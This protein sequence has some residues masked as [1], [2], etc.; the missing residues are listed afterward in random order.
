MALDNFLIQDPLGRPFDGARQL[1]RLEQGI[2]DA[3]ANRGR[4]ADRLAARPLPRARAEAFA[5]APRALIDNKASNRFTVIEVNAR[6]R[7]ALLSDLAHTL[8]SAKA[9]IKSAHVA[10]YGERAVDTFYVTDLTGQ[11][12]ETPTRLKALEKRLL[13]VAAGNKLELAA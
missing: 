8:F 6:D 2:A 4:L 12:I 11:K 7:P 13:A 5:I 1:A 9:T 3:L 10:T